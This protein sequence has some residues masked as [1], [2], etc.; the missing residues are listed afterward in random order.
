MLYTY[1]PTEGILKTVCNHV[2]TKTFLVGKVCPCMKYSAGDFSFH[3]QQL[4]RILIVLCVVT[5][6]L[7][8]LSDLTALLEYL[9]FV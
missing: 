5:V 9:N 3:T 2:F 6:L 8:Y 4:W 1:E 7:E